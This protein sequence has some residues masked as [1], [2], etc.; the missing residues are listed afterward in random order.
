MKTLPGLLAKVKGLKEEGLNAYMWSPGG[1]NFPPKCINS[2]IRD[3]IMFIEEVVGCGE[4]AI[5]DERSTGPTAQELARIV[6]DACVGGMLSNK[7]GVTHLH[8]RYSE[9]FLKDSNRKV[10]LEGEKAEDQA[11]PPTHFASAKARTACAES[12]I[13]QRE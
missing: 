3:D 12:F 9:K 4:V 8:L 13:C 2:S 7:A 1:G 11:K 10:T 5:A 6:L